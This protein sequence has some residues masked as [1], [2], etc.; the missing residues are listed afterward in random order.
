MFK[1]TA[2]VTLLASLLAAAPL[3]AC[4]PDV[5]PTS[6]RAEQDLS[7]W[8]CEADCEDSGEVHVARY[9]TAAP[10][11]DEAADDADVVCG[12]GFD[13]G[14]A[15]APARC[16]ALVSE[17]DA[18]ADVDGFGFEANDAAAAGPTWW[19]CFW[20]C[21]DGHDRQTYA[22]AGSLAKAM[23]TC[24]QPPGGCFLAKIKDTG[25]PCK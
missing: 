16:D 2:P 21:E 10:S 17:D 14:F 3:L 7:P 8:T 25:D 19:T 15:R 6:A 5:A 1:R 11:P 13:D 23:A 24:P 18:V 12:E 9:F 22:C 4:D 20:K